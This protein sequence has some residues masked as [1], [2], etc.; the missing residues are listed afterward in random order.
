MFAQVFIF[1]EMKFFNASVSVLKQIIENASQFIAVTR[2]R[3]VIKQISVLSHG[4]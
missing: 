2:I 3:A 4:I 1:E